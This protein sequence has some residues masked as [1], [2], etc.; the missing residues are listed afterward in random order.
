MSE[1]NVNH[2]K[3]YTKHESGIEAIDICE[4]LGFNIGNAVK[5]LW[6]AG[7][8]GD[9]AVHKT[10]EDMQK[11]RWYLERQASQSRFTSFLTGTVPHLNRTTE[12]LIQRV[13]A[14]EPSTLTRVLAALFGAREGEMHTMRDGDL[15]RAID[16]LTRD[17]DALINQTLYEQDR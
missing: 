13:C 8:K 9:G 3:H 4:R 6:R 7:I 12:G 11:A 2:P 14:C 16:L 17:L 15:K 1:D 5:Y 10:I